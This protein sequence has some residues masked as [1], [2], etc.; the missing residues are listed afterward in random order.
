MMRLD[1]IWKKKIRQKMVLEKDIID[2]VQKWQYA[3][4]ILIDWKR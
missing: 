2:E 3:L 4:D 1:R